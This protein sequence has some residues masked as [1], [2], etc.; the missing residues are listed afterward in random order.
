MKNNYIIKESITETQKVKFII[1]DSLSLNR[2]KDMNFSCYQKG[3]AFCDKNLSGSWWPKIENVLKGQINIAD[4][5][6]L[7][8]TEETKSI[9]KLFKE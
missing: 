7:Q 4:I 6:Y 9:E 3:I 1:D 8:P 5:H 2:L